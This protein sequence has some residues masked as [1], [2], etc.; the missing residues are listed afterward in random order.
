MHRSKNARYS[1]ASASKSRLSEI[2]MPSAL[3]VLRLM[4][5]SNFG[6]HLHRQIGQVDY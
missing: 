6:R 1:I 2:L 4:T 5:N 3:A